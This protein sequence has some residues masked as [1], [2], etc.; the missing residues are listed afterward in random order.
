MIFRNNV[1]RKCGD[2]PTKKALK[3]W[4]ISLRR[5][6][7]FHQVLVCT[8]AIFVITSAFSGGAKSSQSVFERFPSIAMAKHNMA[9]VN[10]PVMII[11]NAP[12]V[13]KLFVFRR[14]D[15]FRCVDDLTC[16]PQNYPRGG[17]ISAIGESE[18]KVVVIVPI[19]IFKADER[20][21]VSSGE[22]TDI[23]D[24]D[25]SDQLVRIRS[26]W[27]DAVG[28]HSQ[29]GALE[30]FGFVRLL[31]A[32][33]GSGALQRVREPSNE[34]CG[35]STYCNRDGFGIVADEPKKPWK[36][37]AADKTAE[38]R[39]LIIIS[40]IIGGLMA[41]YMLTNASRKGQ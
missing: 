7:F 14:F 34:N 21:D 36:W 38:T 13:A 39:G 11:N 37:S 5:L 19:G 25:I 24:S 9:A 26:H 10:K 4:P 30:D 12:D 23:D 35:E 28:F 2:R 15:E 18:G 31:L 27:S 17:N 6:Q 33:L 16:L 41:V 3:K 29:I 8:I 20:T 40:G 22:M 1:E 32:E